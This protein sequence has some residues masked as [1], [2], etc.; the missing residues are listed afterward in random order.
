M[1]VA[2]LIEELREAPQ[3]VPVRVEGGDRCA[4]RGEREQCGEV[5]D[6]EGWCVMGGTE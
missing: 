5:A 3:D 1:T 2:E 6:D 4:S